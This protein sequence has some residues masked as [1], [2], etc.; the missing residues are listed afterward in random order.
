MFVQSC[1]NIG[2]ASTPK[3]FHRVLLFEQEELFCVKKK[4][5]CFCFGQLIFLP[6]GTGQ[7]G[8]SE[9]GNVFDVVGVTQ[10]QLVRNEKTGWTTN[11]RILI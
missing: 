2:K 6:R 8:V 1:F 4:I 7:G 10:H 5:F 11:F 9:V 3:F